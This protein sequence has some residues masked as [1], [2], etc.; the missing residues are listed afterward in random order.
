MPKLF[1]RGLA[2]L[3]LPLSLGLLPLALGAP[4]ARAQDFTHSLRIVVPFAPGGT[5]DI[6]ARIL[7]PELTRSIGQSVV[8]ENRPGAAGN[9]GADAVAKSA[10]DG[11]TVL[12]IDAGILATAPS[13]FSKLPFDVKRDLTPVSML[14]Y[15]PYI[16]A[17]HPSLPVQDGAGLAAYARSNGARIN[18]AHSGIGG[19]N[20]L[21]AL[22]LAGHWR[23]ELTQ[24][25]YRGGAAALAAAASGEANL[26]VNGATATQPFVT[27]GQLRG[28]A[29]SGPRRLAALPQVPTFAELGWPAQESGT[30]QG[31]LVAG[32]TPPAMVARLEKEFRQA[33]AQPAIAAR[34]AE[35]GGDIRTEGPAAFRGWLERETESW[36]QVIRAARISLD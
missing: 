2:A 5:S 16:V 7:A 9:I 6:L 15:A 13:L 8:V 1:R 25:P 30:Y 33:L 24:V 3:L 19:A 34:V 18:V 20:H 10:P 23:A 28:I 17:V 26:I 27:G 14:I 21:A 35:L 31:I 32:G 4:A 36:G 22:V 11:H 12:L 29:V